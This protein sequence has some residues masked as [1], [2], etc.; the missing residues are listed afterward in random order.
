MSMLSAFGEDAFSRVRNALKALQDGRGIVLIDDE[1]RE[2]E[3]DL[4]FAANNMQIEHMATMINDCSGIIC[5]CLT[6]EKVAELELPMMVSN[7]SSRY[8][9][10]FTVSIEAKTGVTTGVSAADRLCTIQ[11]AI[12][13][14]ATRDSLV[15]PGHV[16]PIR[17][18]DGGVFTRRGH[19]EG[20]VDLVKL[21]NLGDSAVL[22]E[23]CN[24]DGSMKTL[25]ALIE[26]AKANGYPL[27]TIEDIVAY[28]KNNVHEA[29]I[30]QKKAVT[31]F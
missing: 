4:V 24:R 31:A 7:N 3:G 8:Q 26:Y 27:L 19:T 6:E 12:N 5:L 17:A 30:D 9:T 2:N 15:Y 21:A 10:G 18:R 14:N 1:D 29:S 16:F 25:P 22:C 28:R 20:S 13:P 11:T 23:L